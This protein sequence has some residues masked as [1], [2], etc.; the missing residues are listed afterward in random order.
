MSKEEEA[1]QIVGEVF[2][3]VF[4][5]SLHNAF[6]NAFRKGFHQK[7]TKDVPFVANKSDTVPIMPSKGEAMPTSQELD[8]EIMDKVSRYIDSELRKQAL[9]D[10][11]KAVNRVP[12]QGARILTGNGY[13]TGQQTSLVASTISGGTL[14]VKNENTADDKISALKAAEDNIQGIIDSLSEAER[15]LL[16]RTLYYG[17]EMR[18]SRADE[19]VRKA[20]KV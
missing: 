7:L 13:E 2:A 11:R 8:R 9:D 15:A 19:I 20:Y 14:T 4:G 10:L 1:Q 3:K 17:H 12:I 16:Y 5:D 18:I 6:V